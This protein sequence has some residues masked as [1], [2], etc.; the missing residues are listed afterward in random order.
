[1]WVCVG[2]NKT[3]TA[4][5]KK[6]GKTPFTS[7]QAG[8]PAAAMGDGAAEVESDTFS[9]TTFSSLVAQH[10]R[11]IAGAGNS[12]PPHRFGSPGVLDDAM[13]VAGEY[14]VSRADLGRLQCIEQKLGTVRGARAERG[15]RASRREDQRESWQQRGRELRCARQASSEALAAGV[16]ARREGASASARDVRT[17]RE[18]NRQLRQADVER[19]EARGRELT[20]QGVESRQRV[21]EGRELRQAE[22][23]REA[24]EARLVQKRRTRATRDKIASENAR[25]VRRVRA[26]TADS[27]VRHAKQGA[28]IS[29]WN[30]AEG[31]RLESA[32]LREQRRELQI[33]FLMDT[34]AAKAETQL[35]HDQALRKQRE[36]HERRA[37]ETVCDGPPQCPRRARA[38]G[39]DPTSI[40][41]ISH[42]RAYLEPTLNLCAHP[43]TR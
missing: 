39:L 16:M 32:L 5:E 20:A 17:R 12:S 36:L 29:R 41:H 14:K 13:V 30:R 24:D 27:V 6:F 8:H 18:N 21:C 43:N 34:Y 42:P 40:P 26:E 37:L 25:C 1:M 28:V 31:V 15:E 23:R 3:K 11:A 33:G 2:R 35:A 22:V 7:G 9:R 4:N 38:E 10:V 19:I